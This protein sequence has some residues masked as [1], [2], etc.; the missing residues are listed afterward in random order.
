MDSVQLKIKNQGGDYVWVTP[1][2]SANNQWVWPG[3]KVNKRWSDSDYPMPIRITSIAGETVED[4]I[5][6]P[7]VRDLSLPRELLANK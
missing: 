3:D 2:R 4:V 1:Q 5:T 6:G 7:G